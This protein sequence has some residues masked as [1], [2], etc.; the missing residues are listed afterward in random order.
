LYRALCLPT[1][2]HRP[3][4]AMPAGGHQ[5]SGPSPGGATASRLAESISANFLLFRQARDPHQHL[6]RCVSSPSVSASPA[7]ATQE[8]PPIHHRVRPATRVSSSSYWLA[9]R[10]RYCTGAGLELPAVA[11]CHARSHRLYVRGPS[12]SKAHQNPVFLMPGFGRWAEAMSFLV[13]ATC[14]WSFGL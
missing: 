14:N 13:G 2:R 1:T 12:H 5:P 9:A 4:S 8:H 6:P 11:S 10:H 7:H 3:S